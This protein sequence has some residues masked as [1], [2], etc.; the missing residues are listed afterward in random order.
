MKKTVIYLLIVSSVTILLNSCKKESNNN[1][2][3]A[4]E[5]KPGRCRVNCNITGA[6]S[7]NYKS[8]DYYSFASYV[9]NLNALENGLNCD[10]VNFVESSGEKMNILIHASGRDSVG[11]YNFRDLK[12]QYLYVTVTK[13]NIS[14]TNIDTSWIAKYG[15]DFNLN[16]TKL[17]WNGMEGTFNGTIQ[18]ASVNGSITPK[19]IVINNG[20]FRGIFTH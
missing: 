8:M 11:N 5:L 18:N 4:G 3:Q 17:D 2:T 13:N 14:T 20:T 1:D 16:I 9:E 6:F 12:A 19:P 7:S 10:G 15:D